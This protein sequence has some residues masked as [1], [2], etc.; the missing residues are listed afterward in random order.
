M[1]H[2]HCTDIQNEHGTSAAS[3]RKWTA[4]EI[5]HVPVKQKRFLCQSNHNLMKMA[6]FFLSLT[7]NREGLH[8]VQT[9]FMIILEGIKAFL[10]LNEVY[11]LFTLEYWHFLAERVESHL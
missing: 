8:S 2:S 4:A 6:S 5:G 1:V 10:D 3:G 7:V 11:L 9:C